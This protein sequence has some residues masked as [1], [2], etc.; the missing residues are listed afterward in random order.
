L[1]VLALVLQ[2]ASVVCS[3]VVPSSKKRFRP[4]WWCHNENWHW[5][6]ATTWIMRLF[7]CRFYC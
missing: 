7:S 1:D 3:I 2:L 4:T 5:W 6:W